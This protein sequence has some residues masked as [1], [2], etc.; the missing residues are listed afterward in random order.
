MICNNQRWFQRGTIIYVLL[1]TTFSLEQKGVT[2]LLTKH[3]E[4]NENCDFIHN[5]HC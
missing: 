5:Q 2:K 1:T 4:G 3:F